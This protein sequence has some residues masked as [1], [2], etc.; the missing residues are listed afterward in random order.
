MQTFA[1]TDG[2]DAYEHVSTVLEIMDLFHFPDVT[3]D[4]IMLRVHPLDGTPTQAL[5]SIQVMADHSHNWYD[6][7]TTRER[8]NDVLDN[9][10]AIHESFKREHLTKEYPLK[11]RTKAIKNSKTLVNVRMIEIPVVIRNAES[12][13]SATIYTT[14]SV[15]DKDKIVK[16]KDQDY[17][18]PP[19]VMQPLTPLDGS[20]HTHLRNQSSREMKSQQQYGSNLSFPYPVANHGVHCYSHSHL[21][22]SLV[23]G[24]KHL[25][26]EQLREGERI[27]SLRIDGSNLKI[28]AQISN[29]KAL[30]RDGTISINRGLIQAITTSFPPQPIE[31]ATRAS[32][33]RR[34]PLGVQGRSHF[35]YFLYLIV[36]NM[37]PDLACPINRLPCHDGIQW[38]L[39]TMAGVDIDTL[40]MEQ[41]LSLSRENQAPGMVKPE[42]GGNVNFE[43]KSQFMREL[44][45][46]TF[47]GNK[48]EDAHDHIDR[49]LNVT[50]LFNI[51]GVTKD[52]V[53]LQ[54][55]PFT[56]TRAAK[57]WV[58]RLAP[59]TINTWDLLKKAFI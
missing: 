46:D 26:L 4:A 3:H 43:I 37:N 41:Y 55:F 51:P 56:L 15:H 29:L 23:R 20:H 8:I 36:Q 57:R 34:I 33:L 40:T 16:E 39:G 1:G 6:E 32:N 24:R 30:L 54:V 31:E 5:E 19:S 13:S 42:I 10:D 25:L 21:I 49:V 38:V 18:I 52:T 50:G 22:S 59:G 2:E 17:D 27:K 58:D 53:M 44:R 28:S 7:T 11:K 12:S 48:D 47:F 45:E 14:G 35:T 9:V